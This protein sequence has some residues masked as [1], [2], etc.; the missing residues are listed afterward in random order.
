MPSVSLLG[1]A[2]AAPQLPCGTLET[3]SCSACIRCHAKGT[4]IWKSDCSAATGLPPVATNA[5]NTVEPHCIRGNN[6]LPTCTHVSVLLAGRAPCVVSKRVAERPTQSAARFRMM[7][8]LRGLARPVK[9]HRRTR[10]VTERHV[11]CAAGQEPRTAN[12]AT[13]FTPSSRQTRVQPGRNSHASR[14]ALA[15]TVCAQIHSDALGC[16]L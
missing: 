1:L 10:L 2:K 7:C 8:G 13:C 11:A 15:C 5:P 14:T 6:V 12:Q 16:G 3:R 4:L 9:R